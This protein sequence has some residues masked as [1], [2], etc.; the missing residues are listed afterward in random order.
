VAI[1]GQKAL[2]GGHNLY[3]R[4]YLDADPIQDISMELEGPAAVDAHHFGDALWGFVCTNAGSHSEVTSFE[5]QAG[6]AQTGPGC[7]PAMHLSHP[8]TGRLLG[9]V[10]VLAIGRLASGITAD[11]A[12][13][14]ELAR[15]LLLG[16]ARQTIRMAQQ[17]IAFSM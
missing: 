5:Y 3:S 9:G 8:D 15:D 14:S 4:D 13:Q 17:D 11:F 12:N 6:A 1:D 16:A 2:V 7:L 10:P